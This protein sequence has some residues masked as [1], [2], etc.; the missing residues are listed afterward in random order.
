MI[1]DATMTWF[2]LRQRRIA[3]LDRSKLK[4]SS[5][6]RQ[7]FVAAMTQF[8]E[9]MKAANVVTAATS[10]INLYYGLAQ[11]GMAIAAAHASGQWSFSRHGLRP[12]DMEPD[13]P[14]IEIAPE[15]EGAFQRIA[16]VTGSPVIET[17]VSV[18][19][20]WA[21][22]PDLIG[23]RPSGFPSTSPLLLTSEISPEGSPR[24]TLYVDASDVADDLSDDMSEQA[25]W[26]LELLSAYPGAKDAQIPVERNAIRA[27]ERPGER[28]VVAVDWP[29]LQTY[30][31]STREEIDLF[32][33][34]IAPEYIYRDDRYLRPRLQDGE[35]PMPSFLMTWWIILYTLSMLAR[36]QP[37]KWMNLLDLNNSRNAVALQYLL[38]L[39]QTRIP[40]LV[41]E[42]LDQESRLLAQP[43]AF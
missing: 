41:L 11:A 26:F 25:R 7:T 17:P 8:E 5:S 38:Q 23:A 14:D 27:P 32:F 18:G 33:D 9:Q 15:G 29:P 22:L 2:A 40:H 28:W 31:E 36:Y 16:A 35:R 13:F 43:L 24:A 4:E 30:R 20:L 34:A 42:A 39:A 19:R 3:L 12:V 21:S 1:D 37:R 10:P 6:R